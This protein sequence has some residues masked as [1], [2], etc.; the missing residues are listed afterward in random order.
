MSPALEA[1]V[2]ITGLPGST[3]NQHFY[4]V[5]A[6][7]AA[8]LQRC[9]E[10]VTHCVPSHTSFSG[11]PSQAWYVISSFAQKRTLPRSTKSPLPLPTA[12]LGHQSPTITPNPVP[13]LVSCQ[14]VPPPNPRHSLYM[15]QTHLTKYHCDQYIGTHTHVGRTSQWLRQLQPLLGPTAHREA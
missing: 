3:L 5:Y 12:L 4:G 7:H 8:T 6:P 13:A 15:Y 11:Q 14:L 2:L 1:R 10:S 9:H